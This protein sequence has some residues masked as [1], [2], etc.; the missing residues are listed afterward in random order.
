MKNPTEHRNKN[1]FK[2]DWEAHKKLF[3]VSLR[4]K[5]RKDF[6]MTK[7][8]QPMPASQF[9][10]TMNLDPCNS[11]SIDSLKSLLAS[12]NSSPAEICYQTSLTLSNLAYKGKDEVDLL[13]DCNCIEFCLVYIQSTPFNI[14]ENLLLTLSN[15]A[16]TGTEYRQK[17]I[18]LKFLDLLPGLLFGQ[19]C[20]VSYLKILALLMQNLIQ[21]D[22]GIDSEQGKLVF[23]V[24][25]NLV[26]LDFPKI[27]RSCL[28]VMYSLSYF[29]G[30]RCCDL[31]FFVDFVVDKAKNSDNVLENLLGLKAVE[32]IVCNPNNDLKILLKK[33]VMQVLEINFKKQDNR[34]LKICCLVL[35]NIIESPYAL[36]FEPLL[37]TIFPGL[38]ECV[39]HSDILIRNEA[40]FVLYS[41]SRLHR[42][43]NQWENFCFLVQND[44]FFHLV[45]ALQIKSNNILR[46]IL[47]FLQVLMKAPDNYFELFQE[48]FLQSGCYEILEQSQ[49]YCDHSVANQIS[50]FLSEHFGG[51]EEDLSDYELSSHN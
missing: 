35:A 5:K 43:H 47:H 48:S 12:F 42:I 2:H 16:A 24:I 39:S 34:I 36:E 30:F 31:E 21:T 37:H 49:L 10:Q 50:S 46:N 6:I 40:S 33:G 18:D 11:L 22:V 26:A 32:N 44:L 51:S 38:L 15:I 27:N 29:E 45:Q 17:I 7:R 8:A 9:T 1:F 19:E 23:V 14:C 3:E 20:S 28:Y 25:E 4:Q 13:L 41:L